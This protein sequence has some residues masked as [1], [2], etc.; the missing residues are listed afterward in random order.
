MFESWRGR[1]TDSLRAI[2]QLLAEVR[3][4]IR[5]VWVADPATEFPD[6]VR[7]VRRHSAEYFALLEANTLLVA[8][9]IITKH[10]VKGPRSTYLQLSLIHI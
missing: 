7:R 6:G 5:Q 2:S 1:Y 8:N 4:D 3:P 9:D 10:I